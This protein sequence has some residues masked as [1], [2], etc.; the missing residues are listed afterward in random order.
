[1]DRVGGSHSS[2]R[3]TRSSRLEFEDR[4]NGAKRTLCRATETIRTQRTV[5]KTAVRRD[6]A[7]VGNPMT[8]RTFLTHWELG[9]TVRLQQPS[10]CPHPLTRFGELTAD[11]SLD[12]LLNVGPR[13]IRTRALLSNLVESL[14]D[15]AL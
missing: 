3:Q 13:L 9:R 14:H 1:M 4:R 11:R 10:L 8:H 5:R 15:R 6:R 7:R 2:Q 12:V